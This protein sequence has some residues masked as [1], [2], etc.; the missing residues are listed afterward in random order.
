L[1]RASGGVERHLRK[2]AKGVPAERRH[3]VA[4]TA[5]LELRPAGGES[6][7]ATLKVEDGVSAGYSIGFTLRPVAGAWEIVAI[8]TPE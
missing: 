2:A 8:S 1:P 3:L 5:G 6:I 7:S 4:H